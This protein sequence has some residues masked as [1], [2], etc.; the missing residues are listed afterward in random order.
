MSI[1]VE[2]KLC[3]NM[4]AN[5]GC[6]LSDFAGKSVADPGMLHTR[7]SRGGGKARLIPPPPPLDRLTEIYLNCA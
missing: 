4:K 5:M 6:V 1:S 3:R 2:P 7:D